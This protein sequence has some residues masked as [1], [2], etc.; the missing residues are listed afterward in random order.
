MGTL[1]HYVFVS[2]GVLSGVGKGITT[3]SIALLLKSRGF[4]T[5]A[6][7]CDMYLNI[8]AGTM[9]PLEHGEVFV[10]DDRVETDQDLGH[11][12]R[13]LNESL[14]GKNYITAGQIYWEVLTRER[15]LGYEGRS[16]DTYEIIPE[17]I[18]KRIDDAASGREIAVIE[19]GGTVG[20][21]QNIM[22]FEAIRRLK[23]RRPAST[24]LIHVGYL[25]L[26]KTLGELKSKP[27]QQSIHELNSLGLRPDFVIARA[28]TPIDLK[29]REKIAFAAAIT[30][31][32]VISNPDVE[33]VYEVPL[34]LDKQSLTTKILKKLGLESRSRDLKEWRKMVENIKQSLSANKSAKKVLKIAL[35]A[36][37]ISSGDYMLEDSYVCVNEAL[38]H[39][40]AENST[41]LEFK[42]V[43]AQKLE[44]I[45][46]EEIHKVFSGVSGIVVPQGWGSR[47]TEGKIKAIKFAR[48]SKTPF[49]G[50]CFGMQMAAIEFGRDVLGLTQANST[51]V[52]PKTKYPII[53]IMPDQEKYLAEKQYGGTIRLGAWDCN[54]IEG[55]LL[56]K[57]YGKTKV[58]ERHRHRYEFNNEYR[59][60]FE[61][62]GVHFSGLSP[63]GKLVEALELDQKLHPFFLGVQFHP[64][65]KSRPL[66]PH[67]IFVSFVKAA[68][69]GQ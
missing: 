61:E 41:K 22:F 18:I 7:K 66:S 1:P 50:L 13:F 17:E 24:L 62:A 42:W 67:P 38:K 44:K 57:I 45:P 28:E 69:K 34:I 33:T 21:H 23:I 8:D 65:L 11:Y 3:A 20:E 31:D 16:L 30:T 29:R 43:D 68:A 12:E 25:P 49:L 55:T 46:D 37:Y 6:I 64:E 54:V 47:G 19:F 15:H 26:P 63:D 52:D 53:H 4:D 14:P 10:T 5:T 51:E 60:R 9:N 32:D 48:E 39:A 40:A 2:G 27:L 36:K 56:A 35:V 58:S 59:R